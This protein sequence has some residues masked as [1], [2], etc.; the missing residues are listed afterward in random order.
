MIKYNSKETIIR[1]EIQPISSDSNDI[2]NFDL[3]EADYLANDDGQEE[4]ADPISRQLTK[5]KNFKQFYSK[6]YLKLKVNI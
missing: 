3:N 4:E 1:D 2:E 5:K 6:L